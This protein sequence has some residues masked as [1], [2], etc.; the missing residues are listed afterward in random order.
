MVALTRT[1]ALTLEKRHRQVTATAQIHAPATA[2]AAATAAA[3]A[4][5][6]AT[7][8]AN[9]LGQVEFPPVEGNAK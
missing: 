4:V 5:A 3:A 9:R 2:T 6:A 8:V 7:A 1:S